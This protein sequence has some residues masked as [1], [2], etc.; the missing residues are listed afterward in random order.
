MQQNVG[1]WFVLLIVFSPL[2]ARQALP[3]P[4]DARQRLEPRRSVLLRDVRIRRRMERF[5]EL[6]STLTTAAERLLAHA[7]PADSP[8]VMRILAIRVEFQKEEPDDPLTTGDGTFRYTPSGDSVLEVNACGD[9]LYN[10]FYEP[11]HTRRYF[12]RQLEALAHYVNLWTYGRV[13]L[14]WRII[15]DTSLDGADPETLAYHLPHTMRYYGDTTHFE[16]G[17]VT[18][19]RDAFYA[20][21]QDPTVSFMDIDRNGVVDY[22]EGVFPRYVIFHAGSAWQTD[23]AGDSPFDIAAVTLPPGIFEYYLGLPFLV[24]NNG[25]DTVYDV[26]LL[27][28]TMSQDSQVFQLQ[29]TLIHESGHN[30]FFQPDLYDTGLY[31]RGIGIGA[32]GIMGSGAYLSVPDAIPPGLL[33]PLPNV[34]ERYWAD[35]MLSLIWNFPYDSAHS[36]LGTMLREVVPSPGGDTLN[37]SPAAVLTDSAGQFLQDPSLQVRFARIP[38]HPGREYYWLEYRRDNLPE[39][40]S[41]LVCQG[42]TTRALVYGRW[43]D[44]VVVHFYGE[45]DYLLPGNGLLIWQEDREIIRREYPTNTV[46]AVRPMGVD[47]VEAD[48]IQDLEYATGN[49]AESYFGGP[50]DPFYR[51]NQ[52]RLNAHTR[53]RAEDHAGVPLPFEIR[54]LSDTGSSTMRVAIHY[55]TGPAPFP[56]VLS[57]KGRITPTQVM[58]VPGGWWLLEQGRWVPDP[59]DSLILH[60]EQATSRMVDSQGQT[61]R[62]D[63]LG[64]VTLTPAG[65]RSDQEIYTADTRGVVTRWAVGNLQPVQ[66]WQRRLDGPVRGTAPFPVNGGVLVGTET[67]LLS[68]LD[69]LTG[70]PIWQQ[71]LGSPV[72]GGVVQAGDTL[73]LETGAGEVVGLQASDGQMLFRLGDPGVMETRS[74]PV[75]FRESDGTLRLLWAASDQGFRWSR[76]TSVPTVSVHP[77]RGRV[78]QP[79]AVGRTRSGYRIYAVV[80]RFLYAFTPEGA[81]AN[82]YPVLF[83]TADLSPPFTLDWNGDGWDEVVLLVGDHGIWVEGAGYVA[84]VKGSPGIPAMTDVDGDGFPELV[85]DGGDSLLYAITL[86][87][88]TATHPDPWAVRTVLPL[89]AGSGAFHLTRLYF[90]PNPVRDARVWLRLESQGSSGSY[91]VR[92]FSFGGQLRAVHEGRFTGGIED[93]AIPVDA[94]SPGAYFAVVDLRPDRGTPVSRRIKLMR[95]VP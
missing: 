18:L 11:P 84:P 9:T 83:P 92:I 63:S 6:R 4:R 42:D 64:D 17:L 27:P 23:A 14:E 24:L 32:W 56:I 26:C 3:L 48:G 19:A 47:L 16:L 81:L 12:E 25:Q 20:A 66:V 73:I 58:P 86:A 45:N 54:V 52:D 15:P 57:G 67:G 89:T 10:P 37:L 90:Y 36:F 82:G 1:R 70:Q 44:G 46:N 21:D 53:P 85:V 91:T 69:T 13:R 38:I 33:V 80:D 29:G 74:T 34:W 88:T 41:T 5:R 94:L 61:V 60:P 62:V 8:L 95:L 39:N 43:K 55:A 22:D 2:Y 93:L 31:P 28:E 75:V 35:S 78:L 72:R 30:L 7:Q 49:D 51:S 50:R 79:L 77:F 59:R 76:L 65:I 40:D 71:S 68:L 87:G